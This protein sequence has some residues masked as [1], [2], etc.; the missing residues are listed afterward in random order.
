[1]VLLKQTAIIFFNLIDKFIHQK[2]ILKYLKKENIHINTWL[3]VGSHRGLYTD[4]IVDNFKIKKGY[5]FEPQKKIFRFI[6]KKYKNCKN[7]YSYNCAISNINKK[8]KIYINKHDLTSS[9]T[10]I[11]EKNLYLKIKA[12][13]FGG[14]LKDMITNQ[15]LVNTITLSNFLNQKKIKQIDLIKVDTEGHE[16]NVLKGLQGKIKFVK[17]ILIE[18]HNNKIYINYSSQ[19][20]HRYLKK[21]NFVLKKRFK[22]PFT[23]WEDRIYINKKIN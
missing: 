21:N 13:L 6:R 9:L 18:F 15:Y 19:K 22:F 16:L 17:N 3:D 10:Q 11:N 14:K 8:Q 7:I 20:I 23:E 1:M 5:L 12:K 2:K 4:L